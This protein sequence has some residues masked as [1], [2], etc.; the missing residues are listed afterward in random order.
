MIMISQLT[1]VHFRC[2]HLNTA[3]GARLFDL[4]GGL[5]RA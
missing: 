1:L 5:L 2:L 4:A 3:L